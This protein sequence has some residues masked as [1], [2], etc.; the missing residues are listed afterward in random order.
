MPRDPFA[1][2]EPGCDRTAAGLVPCCLLCGF[3]VCGM[4][5]SETR[6]DPVVICR[7]GANVPAMSVVPPADPFYVYPAGCGAGGLCLPV[8]WE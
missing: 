5:I 8:L 4:P 2:D 1:A 7:G 6:R 3:G